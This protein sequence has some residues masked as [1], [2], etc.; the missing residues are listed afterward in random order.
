MMH[1]SS[2]LRAAHERRI[3]ATH[4]FVEPHEDAMAIER[5]RQIEETEECEVV[6]LHDT[7]HNGGKN[8]DEQR[9]H[10]GAAARA[11]GGSGSSGS[12]D[13]ATSILPTGRSAQ[14]VTRSGGIQ[15]GRTDLGPQVA[16]K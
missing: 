6:E 1:E 13:V 10:G 15:N 16:T 14:F 12:G 7:S 3:L 8:A 9:R 2:Q 5:Q 4:Q 11:A